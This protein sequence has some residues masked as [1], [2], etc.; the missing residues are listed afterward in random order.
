M[1]LPIHDGITE[2]QTSTSIKVLSERISLPV[3]VDFWAPWCQPC[4]AFSPVFKEAARSL[5]GKAVL[6]KVNTEA[7]PMASDYFQIRG[8]PALIVFNKGAEKSRA[9]GA[10][11]L[12]QFLQWVHEAIG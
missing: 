1:D 3:I 12:P 5:A 9:S 11:A 4:L 6:A 7:S 10:M 8:I 2:L